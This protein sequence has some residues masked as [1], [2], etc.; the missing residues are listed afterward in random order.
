MQ[1]EIGED[2]YAPAMESPED[3]DAGANVIRALNYFAAVERGGNPASNLSHAL[4]ILAERRPKN[5]KISEYQTAQLMRAITALR[6]VTPKV[7][8]PQVRFED[9]RDGL[10]GAFGQAFL[11]GATIE[12]LAALPPHFA[13]LSDACARVLRNSC[14]SA[15]LRDL[16][17]EIY[18][19]HVRTAA[20]EKFLGMPLDPTLTTGH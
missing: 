14:H 7:L 3:I 8:P 11:W 5:S 16:A 2:Q 20:V 1:A 6:A 17:D 13:T 4:L 10:S 15:C 18:Q 19:D 12:Q 9:I